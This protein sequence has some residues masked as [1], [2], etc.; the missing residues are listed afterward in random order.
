MDGSNSVPK[1]TSS[2]TRGRIGMTQNRFAKQRVEILWALR[3]N[4]RTSSFSICSQGIPLTIPLQVRIFTIKMHW[5]LGVM[6][7]VLKPDLSVAPFKVTRIS[8]SREIFACE[9]WNLGTLCL[10]N[11]E[12]GKTLLVKSGTREN[13]TCEICNPGKLCLLNLEPGKLYL[14]NLEPGKTL[15]VKSAT[16]ENFACEIWN[17]GKLCL[18]NL[19]PGKT[20]LVKSGI[21]E[22]F[23]CEI[24]NPGKILLVKSGTRKNFS[25]EIWNLE[26][27]FSGFM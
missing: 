13:F 23:T 2:F 17:P 7:L 5:I 3:T 24:W 6:W 4:V 14:W 18:W 21:R 16:R 1:Y 22:N 26:N 8:G 19:E 20:L 10:R 9:I 27:F 11:L 12:S 25:C 15:L